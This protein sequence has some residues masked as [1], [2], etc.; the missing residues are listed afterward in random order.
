MVSASL[1]A[2]KPIIFLITILIAIGFFVY[3]F[4]LNNPLFW[5]DDD[6]IIRNNFVHTIS[7]DNIKFWLTHNTLAGV[8][9]KSNYYRPFLFFTFALN[10]I[11]SGIKP[12]SYHLFN[13]LIHIANGLLIFIL[14][15]KIF[16]K[17]LFVFLA[18]LIFLI[19]PLQTEAITYVSGRGD[20]L[21]TFFMLLALLFFYKAENDSLDGTSIKK[22]FSLI[23]LVLGLLSRETAIIFPFLAL[24]FYIS[25]ISKERFLKSVKQGLIKTWPYFLAVLVYGLLRLTVL[26]F[27]NTLNFYATPNLYSENLHYRLFTFMHVL[28]D[29]F[30]LLF[31]PTGLHMER[32]MTVHTSLFQWPVWLGA[33][34]I[35]GILGMLYWLYKNRHP[36]FKIWLFGWGVFFIALGP[37]SGI[38]PINALIYEHWLYLPMV[39]FWLIASFYVVKLLD[40]QSAT[41]LKIQGRTLVIVALIA[42]FLFFAYQSIQRNIL[43]GNQLDFYSDIL[44]YE[45]NSVRINNNVGNIYYNKKD[46]ENAEKYYRIA[47]SQDDIFAEPHFNLGTILQSRGDIYGAVKLYEKAI[48]I[49]PNFYYPY[50]N[51][52]VIY[53]QQGNL[54]KA[55]ENIEKLKLL[56]PNNPR[57]YYNSALVYLALDNKTKALEDLRKGLE[58]A[59]SD[60]ETGRLMEELARELSK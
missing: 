29:Y 42:Y 16:K 38:T 3:F 13:N 58:F 23:F 10:Y 21:V 55:V 25:F 50:Q 8:G 24:V 33:L 47:V 44:K 49:N 45:P 39:G 56:I 36:D 22:I 18:S 54:T 37:V 4:N 19:H 6:W 12:F 53:A 27:Q 11:I 57:V 26:N 30:K 7:W 51:L 59:N 40:C 31:V 28:V 35:F 43:W 34:I 48:E 1:Y 20:A 9:M 2:K 5:D 14:V 60:L 17:K 15:Y 46:L 32:S 41:F 52:A